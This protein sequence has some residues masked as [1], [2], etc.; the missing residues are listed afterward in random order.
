MGVFPIRGDGNGSPFADGINRTA[1]QAKEGEA[2][3]QEKSQECWQPVGPEKPL[4]VCMWWS[5]YPATQCFAVNFHSFLK[6]M[7]VMKIVSQ[8]DHFEMEL[9]FRLCHEVEADDDF[10]ADEVI[11][12]ARVNDAKVL[13]LDIEGRRDFHGLAVLADGGGEA[14]VFLHP[15]QLEV[16]G[17]GVGGVGVLLV[18]SH[19]E[20]G[21]GE[22]LHVEEVL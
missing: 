21:L 9:G 2:G 1:A 6:P 18:F 20:G 15:V 7:P 16:A 8:P 19:V 3:K 10:I 12:H 13:P 22:L 5:E 14:N 4:K 11:C 17:D